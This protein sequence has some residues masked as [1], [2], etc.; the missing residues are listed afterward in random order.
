MWALVD[1]LGFRAQRVIATIVFAPD[2]PPSHGTTVVELDGE[3]LMVDSSMLHG[4]PLP[5][6]RDCESAV[7]H[8]AWGMRTRYEDGSFWFAVRPLLAPLAIDCRLD[9][10]GA[11]VEQVR[12]RHDATREWGPMNYAFT[13][14]INRDDRVLGVAWGQ[15]IEITPNGEF[16]KRD[17]AAGELAGWLVDEVGFS[18]EIVSRLPDDIPT[19]AP[20]GSNAET[21]GDLDP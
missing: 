9:L 17:F 18:E 3:L 14:R 1:A 2:L 4:A 21:L 12:E 19:P 11:S 15:H 8:P 7:E 6:R 13:L 10:I 20:P 5:L 16:T